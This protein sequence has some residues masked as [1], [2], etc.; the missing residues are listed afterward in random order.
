MFDDKNKQ[1]LTKTLNKIGQTDAAEFQKLSGSFPV[2]NPKKWSAEHP[3][4]YTLTL[5]LLDENQ[6]VLE[7]FSH[8]TG[9]REVEIK[10]KAV[11]VN[12]VPIKLKCGQQPYDAPENGTR[13]G[14]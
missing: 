1:I 12:G 6:K 4:L 11:Y 2:E 3:N 8:K 10:N 13:D 9:F 5:E 14:C 7:V